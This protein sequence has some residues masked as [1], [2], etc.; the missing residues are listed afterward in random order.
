MD[1]LVSEGVTSLLVE[2]GGE[3][4]AS[5][6]LQ[7]LAQRVVFFY[8]PKIIGGREAP[9]GVAG[10]GVARV[11]DAL[12]LEEVDWRRLGNDFLLTGRVIH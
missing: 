5:F 11:S 8:A 12:R 2:G 4:N 1:W 10:H 7:G 9:R 6:I 3:V